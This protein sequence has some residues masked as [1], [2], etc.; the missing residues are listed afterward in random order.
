MRCPPAAIA[1]RCERW[2]YLSREEAALPRRLA[3]RRKPADPHRAL[4]E[5]VVALLEGGDAHVRFEEAVA[6]WPT[7]LRAVKPAGQPF[8]PWHVLEHIRISQ[9]DIVEFTNSPKHVSPEWPRG[10]WPSD[11]SPPDAREW[12]NSVA[13]VIRDGGA[14][15]A[16]ARRPQRLSRGAAAAVTPPARRL[17]G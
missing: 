8:T 11:N 2:A 15:G 3:R 4:R 9:W 6:D 10:Y 7:D 13:Q 14:R 5:H 16:R 1:A 12:D 17:D